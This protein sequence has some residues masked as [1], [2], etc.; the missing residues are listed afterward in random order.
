LIG[1]VS[2]IPGDLLFLMSTTDKKLDYKKIRKE[3][4]TRVADEVKK[5]QGD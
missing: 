5:F 2:D 4:G 1:M 3:Y